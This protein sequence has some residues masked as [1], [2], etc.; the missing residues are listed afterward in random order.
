MP[1]RFVLL[2]LLALA[3]AGTLDAQTFRNEDPVIR[4]MWEEGMNNSRAGT[5]AQVLMDSIGPR[6]AGSPGYDAAVEWVAGK[7]EEW[8]IPVRRERYGTWKGWRMGPVHVDL[9]APHVRTLNAHLLAWSAGTRRP[10]EGE[11]VLLPA[12]ATREEFASWLRTARDT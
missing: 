9:L 3:G 10:V 2:S 12:A 11:V 8:G 5:L 4:R 6:L 7:Y 1:V